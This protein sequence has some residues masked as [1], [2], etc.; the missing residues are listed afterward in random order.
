MIRCD[1]LVRSLVAIVMGLGL[2]GTAQ[3]AEPFEAFLDTHCLKCHGPEKEKGELRLDRLSR[4]FKQ[5]VDAHRW[6]E[7]LEVINA[8]EMP[9]KKE[10]RPTREEIA[11]FISTLDERIKVG[12]DARMAARPAV[13][14]YRL[15]RKEY[16]NTVYDLLVELSRFS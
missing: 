7:V 1:R 15:S 16:P 4:E 14:H 3:A 9:P 11:A 5:G 12:R 2:V 13:S 8:G 10:K 6:R